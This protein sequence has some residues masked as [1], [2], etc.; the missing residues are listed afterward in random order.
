MASELQWLC[1]AF[2]LRGV[3]MRSENL[4]E[5]QEAALEARE[6]LIERDL[7]R[8]IA[9]DRLCAKQQAV[10]PQICS[11]MQCGSMKARELWRWTIRSLSWRTYRY[12]KCQSPPDVDSNRSGFSFL[13]G[14]WTFLCGRVDSYFKVDQKSGLGLRTKNPKNHEQ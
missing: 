4:I 8:S 3:V 13:C 11:R 2:I 12:N 14:R 7:R 9:F 6:L 1:R 5:Q 10:V